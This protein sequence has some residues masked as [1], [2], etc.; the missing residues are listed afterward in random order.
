MTPSR[1]IIPALCLGLVAGCGGTEKTDPC[2]A[3]L[4]GDLV[5]SEAMIDPD[6]SDTGLEWMEVYNASD[7]DIDLKG[8]TLYVA[9][10]DGSKEKSHILPSGAIAKGAYWV[11]GDARGELPSFENYTYGANLGSMGNASGLIGL[12]CGAKVLDE[13][14]Y[15]NAPSGAALQL[16]G[17]LVPDSSNNDSAA[18]FCAATRALPEGTG[19]GTPGKRNDPCGGVGGVCLD[20]NGQEREI[21]SPTVGSLVISEVMA[22]SGAASDTTG[23]W[24]EVAALEDF[25]LNGLTVQAGTQQTVLTS[26]SC[27]HVAQGGFAVL[28]KSDDPTLNGGLPSVLATFKGSLTNSGGSIAISAGETLLDQVSW[29][30]SENGVA[31]QLDPGKTDPDAN[32]DPTNVCPATEPFGDGDL[33]TPGSANAACPVIPPEGQC[34]DGASYRPAVRPTAGQ[35]VVTEIMADPSQVADSAGEW[36]EVTATADVDL[37]GLTLNVI[38][39]TGSTTSTTL[40]GD[41]CLHLAAGDHAVFAK[42][43]DSSVNGGLPSVTAVFSGSLGNNTAS[44]EIKDGDTLIDAVQWS[45]TTPGVAS[46]LNP[47]TLDATSNDDPANFCQA[48]TAYG[49]GDL[50]S[51]GDDNPACGGG[52]DPDPSGQ[53]HDTQADAMRDPVPPTAGQLQITEIQ[54]DPS[55]GINDT[56]GEWFEVKALADV[57]L[58]GLTVLSGA[59]SATLTSEE[60]LRV[61]SGNYIVFAPK[62]DTGLNDGLTVFQAISMS[63][64]NSGSTV[65]LQ[66]VDTPIDTYTYPAATTGVSYQRDPVDPDTFCDATGSYGTHGNLGSPGAENASCTP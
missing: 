1:W 61:A 22:S 12:R 39:S 11:A 31:T 43:V 50:G 56:D 58:N 47:D 40:G 52:G 45:S 8:I 19:F 42:N 60:C 3:L 26:E 65:T 63:L 64:P 29:T 36:L 14:T 49:D 57:D 2:K 30:S 6:G 66:M 5:L 25:D 9:A 7:K 37:N 13:I 34:L 23:E 21:V 33:G 27:L 28:A 10:P 51:P 17:T 55:G 16:D 54:A 4:P 35:L 46:Q 32:D 18:N 48:S 53:C 15:T 24:F 20:E 59:K 38:G 44:V 41:A 62:D